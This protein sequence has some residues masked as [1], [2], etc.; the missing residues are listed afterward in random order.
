[1][2]TTTFVFVEKSEKYEGFF[3]VE[4]ASYLKVW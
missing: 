1:M 4:K 3:I 2:S